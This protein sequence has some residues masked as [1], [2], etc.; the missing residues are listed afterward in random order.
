MIKIARFPFSPEFDRPIQR[1]CRSRRFQPYSIS[2]E[3]ITPTTWSARVDLASLPTQKEDLKIT[4]DESK[5]E[6]QIS[7]SSKTS[8][9]IEGVKIE[10]THNWKR[11]L[12]VPKT[13]DVKSLSSKFD[14]KNLLFTADRKSGTNVPISFVHKDE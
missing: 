11:T 6:L 1:K 12:S 14:G 4:K 7:G 2:Q 5:R 10:S 8:E 3:M 9:I 13:V